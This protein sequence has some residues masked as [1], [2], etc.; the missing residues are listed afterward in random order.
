MRHII[1][2][3]FVLMLDSLFKLLRPDP[4]LIR[5]PVDYQKVQALVGGHTVIRENL[6]EKL[7]RDFK[8]GLI[9]KGE[10]GKFLYPARQGFAVAVIF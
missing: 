6:G 10:I 2:F 9:G 3:F 1:N 8:C 5:R 7:L 4:D